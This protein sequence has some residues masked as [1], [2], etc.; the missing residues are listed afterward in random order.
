MQIKGDRL[1]RAWLKDIPSLPWKTKDDTIE[2]FKCKGWSRLRYYC[3]IPDQKSLAEIAS[4]IQ[5]ELR[6]TKRVWIVIYVDFV[7]GFNVK[8]GFNHFK[9]LVKENKMEDS[10]NNEAFSEYGEL[11]LLEDEYYDSRERGW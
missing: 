8:L 4:T 7:C 1:K 11:L 9:K 10:I 6:T 3:C 2:F 5:S